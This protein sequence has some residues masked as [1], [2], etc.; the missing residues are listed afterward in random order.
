VEPRIDARLQDRGRCFTCL[1]GTADPLTLL[2]HHER[3]EGG[4][5]DDLAALETIGD[6]FEHQ[7]EHAGAS[8]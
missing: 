4:K 7:L 1:G 3:S 8:A 5:L 6:L 2:A